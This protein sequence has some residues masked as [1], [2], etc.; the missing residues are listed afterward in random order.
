MP[1]ATQ[2]AIDVA[3]WFTDHALN[4]NEYLQPQKLQR[5]LFLAQAYYAVAFDGRKLTPAVFVADE[6][7]PIEPNVFKAFSKGR[8]DIDPD[9]FLPIEVD[10][11]LDAVWRRF[12][13]HS[14]D[15]L[16][17]LSKQTTAYRRAFRKGR[18]AEI[19][20]NS[21]RLSFIRNEETP[22][23]EG[24]VKPKMMRSQEGKAVP[25]KAWVPGPKSESRK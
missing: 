11:F 2:S 22:N 9:L 15:H 6:M 17:R 1:A 12:G 16:T 5:L 19:S 20:L 23:V 10:E 7:G 18:R 13:H 25:V 4:Q 8:P 14:V 3:F 24:V 21:M